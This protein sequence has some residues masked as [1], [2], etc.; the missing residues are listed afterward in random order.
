MIYLIPVETIHIFNYPGS[1][2]SLRCL[3]DFDCVDDDDD[4][5]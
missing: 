1:G 4:D 2:R 3:Y 5:V